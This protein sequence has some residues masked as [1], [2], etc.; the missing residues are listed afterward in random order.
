MKRPTKIF[1]VKSGVKIVKRPLAFILTDQGACT[2]PFLARIVGVSAVTLRQRIGRYGVENPIV[3]LPFGKTPPRHLRN[4]IMGVTALSDYKHPVKERGPM[5]FDRTRQC[6]KGGIECKQYRECQ[7]ARLAASAAERPWTK[8][9]GD[10]YR[11][12]RAR[13]AQPAISG[14]NL[15]L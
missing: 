11:A 12:K 5:P 3:L 2:A 15:F 13:H 6:I 1:G 7:D 9:P 10:C 4:K 14:A 8:P